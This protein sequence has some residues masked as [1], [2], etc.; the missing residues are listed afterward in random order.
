MAE[1]CTELES[2]YC[3]T[4]DAAGSIQ[5]VHRRSD[6]TPII[7][8][9][10]DQG[11][12]DF[13]TWAAHREP[14]GDVKPFSVE[15]GAS[16]FAAKESLVNHCKRRGF[17]IYTEREPLRN[18]HAIQHGGP[19]DCGTGKY[20][21]CGLLRAAAPPYG[22]GPTDQGGINRVPSRTFITQNLLSALQQN[23]C[24]E[25]DPVRRLSAWPIH[26]S[27]VYVDISDFSRYRPGPE[28]LIINSLAGIVGDRTF[29]TSPLVVDAWEAIEAWMCIGDGYI[30]VLKD[31]VSATCFA[32][33]LARLIE[34]LV[35]RKVT[36]VEFH[37]RM[38]IH[39]GPVYCFWDPG[40]Q[41]WNFIGDGINGGQRVLAAIGKETDD[42]LYV[43]QQV[44]QEITAQSDHTTRHGH[45]LGCL[46]NRGRRS[47]KH[48]NVWRVYEVNHT[49]LTATAVTPLIRAL[50]REQERAWNQ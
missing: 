5:Q 14:V 44:R 49:Q 37:F 33:Y 3:V 30:F 10:N 11:F 22:V 41:D 4:R 28:A 9:E 38:G 35:A 46:I 15:P 7:L 6:G 25:D 2:P 17:M 36:P 24:Q 19:L 32:A 34:E 29:W 27:F 18:D 42:V 8:D 13:L 43:S 50:T 39:C 23:L 40:R 12:C 20:A 31:A 1:P 21:F 16:Y 26:R 45:V 47:D 48:G